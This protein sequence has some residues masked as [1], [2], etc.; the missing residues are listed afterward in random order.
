VPP[1]SSGSGVFGK[2][3]R[4]ASGQTVL[5]DEAYVRESI[6]NPQAKLVA[7]YP[8]IMPTYQGLVSEEGLL[9]LVAYVKSLSSGPASGAPAPL[10]GP[11]APPERKAATK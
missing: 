7:G 5:V 9:Q 11:A 8:P 1:G 10:P 6:V 2:P 4:L 3:Q